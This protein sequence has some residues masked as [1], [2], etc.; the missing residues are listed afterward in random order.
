VTE[1]KIP[2]RLMTNIIERVIANGQHRVELDAARG[3][4][5]ILPLGVSVAHA[6]A[7][8]LDAEIQELLGHG[9]APH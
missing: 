2:R 7:V 3:V 6:D 4:A 8:A 5:V 1:V 9:N